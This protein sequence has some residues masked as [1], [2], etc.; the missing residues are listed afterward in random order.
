MSSTTK[1]KTRKNKKA[2]LKKAV[3][4]YLGHARDHLKDANERM[5]KLEYAFRIMENKPASE[6]LR[7]L[8][9][10]VGSA[11]A[12]LYR[13]LDILKPNRRSK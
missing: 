13:V 4:S 3:L 2:E 5:A 1:R 6:A 12:D 7:D 11:N 9:M 8:R 10:V